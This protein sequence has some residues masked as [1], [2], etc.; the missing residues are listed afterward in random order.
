MAEHLSETVLKK[1]HVIMKRTGGACRS[2]ISQWPT[3]RQMIAD[4]LKKLQP[5]PREQVVEDPFD[6]EDGQDSES[7][8][9]EV[10]GN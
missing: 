3:A 2:H 4:A 7:E 5:K 8:E 9:D 10:D 6:V 1:D